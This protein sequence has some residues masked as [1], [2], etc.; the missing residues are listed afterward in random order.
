MGGGGAPARAHHCFV[1]LF[2]PDAP[3]TVRGKVTAVERVVPH[4]V[5][6]VRGADAGG[7]AGD[8]IFWAAPPRTLEARG[9]GPQLL[10]PGVGVSVLGFESLDHKCAVDR[11]TARPTCLA[12]G[13]SLI[14]GSS[15][16]FIGTPGNGAPADGA[17]AE[18]LGGTPNTVGKGAPC[19]GMWS[20]KNVGDGRR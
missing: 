10:K 18:I 16:F 15:R 8:W 13:R 5:I 17:N 2:D 12:E 14:L 9:L 3:L 7:K 1:A 6:H 20:R 19:S 11:R 4:T